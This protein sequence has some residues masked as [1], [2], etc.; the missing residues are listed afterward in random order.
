[1]YYIEGISSN[2]RH[3][4]DSNCPIFNNDPLMQ[5]K[6]A[7]ASYTY[8]LNFVLIAIGSELIVLVRKMENLT[9]SDTA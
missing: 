3:A 9:I 4:T 2:W 5:K 6:F 8:S 7:I 1:M